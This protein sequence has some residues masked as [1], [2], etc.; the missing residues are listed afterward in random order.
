MMRAA[1]VVG[2]NQ[3]SLP[4]D[5]LDVEQVCDFVGHWLRFQPTA[6]P[7]LPTIANWPQLLSYVRGAVY[8]AAY[9]TLIGVAGDLQADA[10]AR[11]IADTRVA[12]D[13]PDDWDADEFRRGF[14]ALR[15]H[16]TSLEQAR[17]F[18]SS[19]DCGVTQPELKLAMAALGAKS[20][21]MLS[22]LF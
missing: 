1:I 5:S 3:W 19:P 20:P 22:A 11:V 10:L 6:T 17:S 7:T 13:S 4:Y 12:Y 8:A 2:S 18:W 9:L 14:E 16:G 21:S 15:A